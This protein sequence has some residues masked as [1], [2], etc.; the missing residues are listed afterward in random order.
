MTLDAGGTNFIFSAI[1]AYKEIVEPI[2]RPSNGDNLEL[3]LQTIVEGFKAVRAQLNEEPVAISFAFP[4]PADYPRGIIGDL[5]NLPAFKGGVALGPMLEECFDLPVY[6]NN[7][8]DLY[9]YGEA[10]AGILPEINQRLEVQSS[11]KRFNNL[12]GFTLGTGFGGG[13]VRNQE[14]F[15][16]D[17]SAGLEVWI[18]S[19]PYMKCNV[20]EGVSIRAVQRTYAELTGLSPETVPSPKDIFE[21]G[22]GTQEGDQQAA[23]ESYQQMGRVIGDVLANIS[24]LIDGIVVIGGGVSGAK[25]LFWPAMIDEMNRKYENF[26]GESYR[27]LVQKVYDLDDT[28]QYNEF[29]KGDS[30]LVK[31]PGSNK[32]IHY[33]FQSRIGIALSRIGTSK[34]ISIGAYSFALNE[35]DKR[36]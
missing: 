14:L 32:Q 17:N 16:G 19:S 27:R 9:A 36:F 26:K 7:D 11:P 15:L 29:L 23:I 10:I 2:S 30:K 13:L 21:I 1:C 35:V 25:E 12:V 34:A 24:T 6:I 5:F 3:C 22:I 18:M 4:G 33:D 28:Q 8:G 20:E 31:V